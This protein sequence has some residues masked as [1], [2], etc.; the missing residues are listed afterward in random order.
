MTGYTM[1]GGLMVLS[2][3]FLFAA[4]CQ[5]SWGERPALPT[6]MAGISSKEADFGTPAVKGFRPESPPGPTSTP[7]PW[8]TALPPTPRPAPSKI[9]HTVEGKSQ[10][11]T[12]HSAG[13]MAVPPDHLRRKNESCTGCHSVDYNAV[14]VK[15]SPVTHSLSG[16]EQCLGCHLRAIEGARPMP[17]EH[18]GRRESECITCHKP[19]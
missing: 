11:L 12:C 4:G 9:L 15:A 2:A 16:R 19:A 13:L 6:A 10:C 18:T 7:A 17:G 14:K 1:K 8:A 3:A 5:P